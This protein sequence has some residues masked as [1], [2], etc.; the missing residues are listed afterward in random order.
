MPSMRELF[1]LVELVIVDEDSDDWGVWQGVKGLH[2]ENVR[3]AGARPKLY[4][5]FSASFHS[6][7][8]NTA[9]S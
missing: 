1:R 8:F 6:C 2:R 9:S 7:T 3:I 4:I 5:H